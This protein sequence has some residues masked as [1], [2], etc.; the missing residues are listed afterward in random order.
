MNFLLLKQ[1]VNRNISCNF[2]LA[3]VHEDLR[4]ENEGDAEKLHHFLG[5]RT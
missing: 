4:T 3:Y 2:S 1:P 5:K